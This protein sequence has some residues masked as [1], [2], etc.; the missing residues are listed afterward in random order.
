MMKVFFKIGNRGVN[1]WKQLLQG[2]L[3]SLF[4]GQARPD[5]TYHIHLSFITYAT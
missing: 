2:M 5:Q 3:L 4:I 1:D